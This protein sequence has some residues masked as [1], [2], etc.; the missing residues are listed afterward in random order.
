M[1]SPQSVYPMNPTV[2]AKSSSLAL[3]DEES[4]E[5]TA[6]IS[7]G[8]RRRFVFM[9]RGPAQEKKAS[10]MAVR[11]RRPVSQRRP[12]PSPEAPVLSIF[13]SLSSSNTVSFRTRRDTVLPSKPPAVVRSPYAA[14]E[15]T[16]RA[17][18]RRTLQKA[19]G[20]TKAISQRGPSRAPL[21]TVVETSSHRYRR[22]T[23]QQV[24]AESNVFFSPRDHPVIVPDRQTR[25]ADDDDDDDNG[26]GND[27][28]DDSTGDDDDDD[29]SDSDDDD[30][31]DE[32]DDGGVDLT[33]L[34]KKRTSDSETDRG[35]TVT[36][37]VDWEQKTKTA[38]T[39]TSD[40]RK[41]QA[42]VVRDIINAD[43]DLDDGE[44]TDEIENRDTNDED[45]QDDDFV[46]LSMFRKKR[47]A[48]TDKQREEF[49]Q[50]GPLAKSDATNTLSSSTR[51]ERQDL[52]KDKNLL[53]AHTGNERD[54]SRDYELDRENKEVNDVRGMGL[55][56]RQQ[57]SLEQEHAQKYPVT[58]SPVRR[59]VRQQPDPD[60][61]PDD[62]DDE[63]TDALSDLMEEEA[64]TQYDIVDT[65]DDSES[66]FPLRLRRNVA[67]SRAAQPLHHPSRS[68]PVIRQIPQQE[69]LESDDNE[70]TSK[71]LTTRKRSS[72]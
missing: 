47:E 32:E 52:L 6:D 69:G 43:D 70:M 31:N 39:L 3:G 55:A 63:I 16:V 28:N 21:P 65:M 22:D 50:Q 48:G 33:M 4:S 58:D 19:L 11:H 24:P 29:D 2:Q 35:E 1:D 67:Q 18:K 23:G 14:T 17:R 26:S 54:D 68:Y 56:R 51:T 66:V 34:R 9:G 30:V 27:D 8:R 20:R 45:Y 5:Q 41:R 49:R 57:G 44:D 38:G 46:D 15:P 71:D 25:Q 12:G 7:S 72:D 40:R 64:E 37:Q 61:M 60:G 59:V 62:D 10:V 13:P 42:D 53:L 36:G